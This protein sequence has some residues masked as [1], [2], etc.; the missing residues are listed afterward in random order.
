MSSI[1]KI[2]LGLAIFTMM[3]FQQ[4]RMN[5]KVVGTWMPSDKRSHIKIFKGTVG[6]SKGSFYGK[7]ILVVRATRK[8]GNLNWIKIIQLP[9]NVRTRSLA[10]YF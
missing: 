1:S 6:A 8:R 4:D 9:R 7:L 3:S 10:C 2:L 5:D